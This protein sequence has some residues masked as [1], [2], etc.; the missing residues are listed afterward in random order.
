MLSGLFAR[1]VS[2]EQALLNRYPLHYPLPRART[3]DW[4]VFRVNLSLPRIVGPA[5]ALYN[6]GLAQ[7]EYTAQYVHPLKRL[8]KL[9]RKVHVEMECDRTSSVGVRERYFQA[10]ITILCIFFCVLTDS[11]AAAQQSGKNV[12]LLVS[13]VERD[14]RFS[15]VE[16]SIRSRVPGPITFHHSYLEASQTEQKSYLESPAETFRRTYAGMKLDLVIAD[17][18]EQL[19][20]A[21]QYRDK[22]LPGVPIVFIAVSSRELERQRMWPGTTGVTGSVGLRKRSISPSI[23][24]EIRIQWQ[25]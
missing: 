3:R 9:M 2:C 19:K 22:I 24:I 7:Y 4:F 5:P 6:A 8:T 21:V 10:S 13:S 20:F 17:N 23:F 25:S 14:S 16:L 15:D 11:T 18:P 1:I 12:L